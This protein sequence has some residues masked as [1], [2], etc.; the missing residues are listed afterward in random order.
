[1]TTI[2]DLKT[3]LAKMPMQMM[4][5]SRYGFNCSI[6]WLLLLAFRVN[7]RRAFERAAPI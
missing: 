6:A 1:M 4:H 2:L 7:G 3:T 5:C